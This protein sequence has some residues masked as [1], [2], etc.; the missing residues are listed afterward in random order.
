MILILKR[1]INLLLFLQESPQFWKGMDNLSGPNYHGIFDLTMT[2]RHDSEVQISYGNLINRTTHEK[3]Q[4]NSFRDNYDKNQFIDITEF[5]LTKL[6]KRTN[7]IAWLVSHCDTMSKREDYVKEMQKYKILEID[8]F[9]KCGN[10]T[11]EIPERNTN[12]WAT[13]T[14]YTK[15]ASS[16]KFYLSFE[17][18]RCYDYITEKFF[19][20]LKVGM[21]PVVLGGLS[22]HD[23]EKI[24]P[25]HSFLHIDDFLSP[26]DLM[27]RMHVIANNEQ[28]YN[29]YFWWRTHYS[30]VINDPCCSNQTYIDPGCQLCSIL[31][32]DDFIQKNDYTNFTTFWNKCRH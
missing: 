6:T 2:Y 10:N 25:P 23:Y 3:I 8:V 26:E 20:A 19:L 5:G 22:K 30:V 7:D 28:I 17:N 15:L 16:Y 1:Q 24:A 4:P 31:N 13:L 27:K 11:S 12:R 29:S 18:S 21:I 9:G 14:A 32:T